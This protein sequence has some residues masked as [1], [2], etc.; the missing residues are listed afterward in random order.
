MRKNN[1][2]GNL[3]ISREEVRKT[4][5]D[6]YGTVHPNLS[7][8]GKRKGSVSHDIS[9]YESWFRKLLY[10]KDGFLYEINTCRMKIFTV[11]GTEIPKKYDCLWIRKVEPS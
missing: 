1:S 7:K 6:L 5:R 4:I 8:N 2:N 3:A 10:P 11:T 9:A